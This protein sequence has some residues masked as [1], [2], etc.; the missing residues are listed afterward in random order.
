MHLLQDNRV[1]KLF[2]KNTIRKR[3][4]ALLLGFGLLPFLLFGAYVSWYMLGVQQ[5]QVVGYQERLATL[6]AN[7]I[8][9]FFH[10]QI[11]SINIHI[12]ENYLQGIQLDE[13]D[14]KLGD[15]LSI[16]S[17]AGRPHIFYAAYL[18]DSAG[19]EIG[20]ASMRESVPSGDAPESHASSKEFRI[21]YEQG[22]NY[23][24]PIFFD[25]KTGEPMMRL[26]VPVKDLY[27][28]K[29]LYVFI[30]ELRVKTIWNILSEINTGK[31]GRVF[32]VNEK[33]LVVA[34]VNPSVVLRKTIFQMPE[35]SGIG[36]GVSGKQAFIAANKIKLGAQSLYLVAELPLS[37]AYQHYYR[38]VMAVL[39]FMVVALIGATVVAAYIVR[40]L[41]DPIESLAKTANEV[42]SGNLEKRTGINRNDELGRFAYAFD[43][44]MS[45]FVG[46]LNAIETE[47]SFLS[48]VIES[49]AYPLYVIDVINSKIMLSNAAA[50]QCVDGPDI[51]KVAKYGVGN[52]DHEKP[53][54]PI[55]EIQ[56]KKRPFSLVY[57]KEQPGGAVTIYELHGYPVMSG[58]NVMQIIWY[59]IDVTEKRKLE[60]K[61][62]QTQKME[63][64]G[65][66]AGGVAHDFNNLL[67]AIIG[68][69]ELAHAKLPGDSPVK[70]WLDVIRESGEIGA[71]LTNQ[72]L[73]FSRKQRLNIKIF[74][75][76]DVLD[77]ISNVLKR[78]AGKGVEIRI[79]HDDAVANV[80]ADESQVEQIF[81]NITVNAKDAMPSGG[82][83]DISVENVSLLQPLEGHKDMPLGC[84]VHLKFKDDGVG[85]TDEVKSRIFEPF[86][87]TKGNKGNG[88]G[89][90]TVYGIVAQHKGYIDVNTS[91]GKGAVFHVYLPTSGEAEA[92][93]NTVQSHEMYYGNETILV[94]DEDENVVRYVRDSLS[95]HGYTA[96]AAADAK[97]ALAQLREL[98]GKIDLL[99][100][101]INMDGMDGH[102]L[103]N[104]AKS[105]NH[106]IKVLLITGDS[107]ELDVSEGVDVIYKPLRLEALLKEVRRLLG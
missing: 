25:E 46:A 71:S 8:S 59:A 107:H 61:L 82:V 67:T 83:L 58:G 103:A 48:N 49:F 90:A 66:L 30:A 36:R 105:I 65:R 35:E 85:M 31:R 56:L 7:N 3:L 53:V 33:G 24:G 34:H 15:F 9:A 75:P 5:K 89:L 4:I 39:A 88:L 106:T 41:V 86:F 38:I 28:G 16:A 81:I 57:E 69:S 45:R 73:V 51:V 6:A 79:S 22:V 77:R 27:S 97:D 10:E 87:T 70:G 101:D 20:R 21:P 14:G 104:E 37:E 50:T 13:V 68:Y 102:A 84:Y 1:K 40:N 72:L 74:N 60:E 63:A 23:F 93:T 98:E 96:Y 44:M 32:I 11:R 94:V 43:Y 42:S 99:V 78:L 80:C 95:N 64:L 17:D 2:Y 62:R 19:Q 54:L 76:A 26:G 100:T 47:K 18:I 91:P 12:K 92:P 52:L 55:E 29:I